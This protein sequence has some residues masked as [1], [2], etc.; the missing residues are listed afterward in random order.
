[1]LHLFPHWNWKGREGDF[2][3]VMC[4]TNCDD[5][6]LFLN[7]KSIGRKGYEFP[8]LGMERKY[9][10]YPAR[11]RALRTTQDL[12]LEWDVP[13]MAGTLK[14]VGYK[15]SAIAIE[16][17]IATTGDPAAVMLAVDRNSIKADRR[18]VVHV[19]AHIVDAQGRVVP[20]AGNE[21]VFD[22]EGEGKLIGVDNG[23]PQSHEDFKGKRRMAFNGLCLA[24]A[25]STNRA[26]N[27]NITA[28]SNALN[29]H[30]VTVVTSL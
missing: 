12:H 8:R 9:G 30:N 24:I 11:A 21:I 29:P 14:A 2:I 17:E 28:A 13:Y 23:N 4:Y 19:T 7:G 15:D 22:V 6:E 16:T 3:P 27:M 1:M 20:D 18:D 5:V 25:Q 10:T 26:G